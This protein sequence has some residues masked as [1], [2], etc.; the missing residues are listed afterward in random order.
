MTPDL[1]SLARRAV[2][3]RRWRWMPG[4]RDT[5]GRR[6]KKTGEDA[7]SLYNEGPHVEWPSDGNDAVFGSPA[8]DLTDAATVGCLLALVR[9]AYRQPRIV[10]VPLGNGWWKTWARYSRDYSPHA[11]ATEAAALVRALEAAP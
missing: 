6:Y 4:M 7:V 2:A 9:E 3:C 1:E 8:P 11:G 10:V 5:S